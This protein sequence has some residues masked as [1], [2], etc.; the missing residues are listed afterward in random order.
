[1]AVLGCAGVF[2][3]PRAQ[4]PH[5]IVIGIDGLSVDGVEKAST[6][7]LHELMA[8]G[9]WTLEARGVM[10]TLSSPNWESMI[11]GAPPEQHGITSNGYFRRLVEFAPVCQDAAGKFPTI[12]GILRDQR[13]QSR[14]AIFH[15]WG[16]FAN[17]VEARAPDVMKHEPSGE[18]T[19][20]AA[21]DYWK[22]NRPALMFVHLDGADHAG[23]ETNWLSGAYYEAVS[24]ADANAGRVLDMVTEEHA[25]DSTFVLVTSDH[26]GT[27]HGHGRN[28]LAEILIPWILAGPGVRAGRLS[29]PVN[30][31]DTAMTLAWIYALETP[32][33]WTGRPVVA[34]FEPSAPVSSTTMKSGPLAGCAPSLPVTGAA[35]A[36]PTHSMPTNMRK[37]EP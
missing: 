4:A 13:P 10:P 27:R 12:F 20:A 31:Y 14:I 18:R 21:L 16:G 11:G 1:M 7:R 2:A 9:A 35:L 6:P 32:P 26:G 15:E 28:S 30:T 29:V 33:C 23:H 17:L 3:Q 25:W 5:V 24:Q 37:A 34:A 22:A 19:I 36:M 8:R